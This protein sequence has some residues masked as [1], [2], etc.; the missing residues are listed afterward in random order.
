[1]EG[2]ILRLVQ[3]DFQWK[4][5]RSRRRDLS[6]RVLDI[7]LCGPSFQ[8][9]SSKCVCLVHLGFMNNVA[10]LQ[11]WRLE[12]PWGSQPP[13]GFENSAAVGEAVDEVPPVESFSPTDHAMEVPFGDLDLLIEAERVE[14]S[15]CTKCRS[16]A[17]T[18]FR[19][20]GSSTC[21]FRVGRPAAFAADSRRLTSAEAS[22]SS[23]DGVEPAVGSPA[24]PSSMIPTNRLSSSSVVARIRPG[25]IGAGLASGRVRLSVKWSE[26]VAR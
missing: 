16:G 1:M 2:R 14:S 4:W 26:L 25:C 15:D 22:S 24:T 7:I 10:D 11:G 6:P 21:P 8:R 13:D 12:G 5:Y 23:S 19:P 9:G 3:G 20:P 17:G 18:L